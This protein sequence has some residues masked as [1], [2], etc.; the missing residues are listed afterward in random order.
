MP[1][2][3]TQIFLGDIVRAREPKRCPVNPNKKSSIVIILGYK[4]S[5]GFET[6]DFSLINSLHFSISSV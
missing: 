3:D 1:L 4:G 2:D 5:S 6:L